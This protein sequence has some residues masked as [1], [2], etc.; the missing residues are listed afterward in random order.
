MWI[1]IKQETS[2]YRIVHVTWRC[3]G[4]KA[5]AVNGGNDPGKCFKC[6]AQFA[7]GALRR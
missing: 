3:S 5:W 1:Q 7:R 2:R 4:C 6:E